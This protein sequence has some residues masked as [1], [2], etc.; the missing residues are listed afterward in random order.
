MSNCSCNTNVI[1]LPCSAS[2]KPAV[3]ALYD[4]WTTTIGQK[5]ARITLHFGGTVQCWWLSL[6]HP[7]SGSSSCGYLSLLS[8]NHNLN[9]YW[10]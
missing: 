7:P 1:R 4:D 10:V 3:F 2:V 5:Q 6:K 9:A 8:T